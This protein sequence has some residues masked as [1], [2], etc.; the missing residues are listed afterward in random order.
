MRAD[1]GIPLY[2]NDAVELKEVQEALEQMIREYPA[3]RR[4]FYVQYPALMDLTSALSDL[5][6]W[7]ER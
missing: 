2:F 3:G 1:P 5:V 6:A 4:A 7:E